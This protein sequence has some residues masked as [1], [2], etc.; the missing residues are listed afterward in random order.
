MKW[1]PEGKYALRSG[2]YLLTKNAMEAGWLYMAY[3]RKELI[4]RATDAPDAKGICEA[5]ETALRRK[6]K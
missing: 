6:R 2:D 5:H 1:Q 3:H 4:G